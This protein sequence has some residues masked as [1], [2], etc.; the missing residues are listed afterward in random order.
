LKPFLAGLGGLQNPEGHPWNA[1]LTEIS[2]DVAARLKPMR[3][4]VLIV[5]DSSTV[6]SSIQSMLL[7]DYEC[8]LAADGVEGLARALAERPDAMVIDLEMPNVDGVQLLRSLK[9]DDRTKAIPVIIVTAVTAV[10]WVN[11]CR[12]AGCAGFALKPIDP[13]YL[14]VKLQRILAAPPSAG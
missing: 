14:R 3:K 13:E 6:R 2:G 10:E 1:H 7:K 11:E 9:G 8:L 12:A 4:R 5:D